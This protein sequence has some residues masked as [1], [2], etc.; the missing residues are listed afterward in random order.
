MK[1]NKLLVL[2]LLPMLVGCAQGTQSGQEE[3][4]TIVDMQ[5]RTVS[6]KK[7]DTDRV[8]C[9]GAGAL[10]FYSYIGNKNNIVAV[11]EIDKTPFG[12]GTAIRPYYHVNKEY[13]ATLPTCGKGGPAAQTPDQEAIAKVNPTMIISFYSDKQVNDNLSNTLHIPVIA[14]KQGGQG[15]YDETTL[16][17]L[18]LL[19][20]VFERES[21]YNELKSYIDTSKEELAKLTVDPEVTYYAGCIGNWGS[22]S[23]V[24][25]MYNFPV[26]KQARVS[27]NLDK[28]IEG[29]TGQVKLEKEE[30]VA[31]NP[32]KI[33]LDG[34]GTAGFI[35]DYK[36]DST[37]YDSLKAF[38]T[39]EIYMLL[40][41]NAYYTNLEIQMMSTYYVA[42]IA[43]PES[44]ASYDVKAKSNEIL[45]KF[46]GKECY[47]ELLDYSTAYGGYSKVNLEE[48][49]K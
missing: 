26:F 15:I 4:K 33:F 40:P 3:T 7:S 49:M 28:V 9:L 8:I 5:D 39:G 34:S 11:E 22:T 13:Y 37:V 27:D 43:H 46:L 31:L 36:E 38:Q 35:A 29:G 14:L 32:D 24:N 23:I 16:K 47:D 20:K 19:G 44:F 12:I 42:S 2:A 45:N 18:E 1:T 48:L 30:L 21:R 25:T 17:S 41:Y 10:R 6:Y